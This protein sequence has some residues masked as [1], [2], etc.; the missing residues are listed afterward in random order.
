MCPKAS[1]PNTRGKPCFYLPDRIAC[2]RRFIGPIEIL[3][4][5]PFPVL[6]YYENYIENT[7]LKYCAMV[8]LA[9][10]GTSA[11]CISQNR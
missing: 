1:V 10:S 9:S 3:G 8:S 6:L 2:D 4:I 7:H 11:Y 5:I